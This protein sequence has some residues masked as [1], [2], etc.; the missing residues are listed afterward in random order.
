MNT[1]HKTDILKIVSEFQ[2]EGVID[3]IEKYGSGHIHETY[4]LKNKNPWMDDYILQQINH[5][6][7]TNIPGLMDN[8]R[9]VTSHLYRKVSEIPGSVP[10][11]EVLTLVPANNGS[12]YY[13]GSDGSYWRIFLFLKGTRSYNLVETT[14]QAYEGGRAYG[15]FQ[16]LL[17]D[18]DAGQLYEILPDFHNLEYRLSLLQDAVKS[19][20]MNRLQY[21]QDLL[22]F[23]HSRTDKMMT[24]LNM[25]KAGKLPVRITHNDTKFNNVLLDKDDR[26]QCVIDLDTV[27]PGYVAY[28]FGDAVRT[29]V[30]TAEED[31]KDLE[32]INVNMYLF[33]GFAKGFIREAAPGLTKNEVDSLSHGCLLLPFIMGV[34]FL[35]D[36]IAGDIYYTIHF[37]D[38]NLQRARAQFRLT[39]KLEKQFPAIQKIIRQL[40]E[41]TNRK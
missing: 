1:R 4:Y 40:T 38:H 25:G 22:R 33:E 29:I 24:I 12:D 13:R 23:V 3:N 32:K 19:D 11:Q 2:V 9:H 18:L 36:Y 35:T 20:P 16:L 8:I 26:A 31:E 28:D 15:R 7:F 17:S 6:V 10:G 30:N 21:G 41:S 34:R 27:M 39:E 14:R 5:K 37:P